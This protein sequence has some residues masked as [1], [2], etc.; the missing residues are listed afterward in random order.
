MLDYREQTRLRPR[1][2]QL[3]GLAGEHEDGGEE[4]REEGVEVVL[5]ADGEFGDQCGG[6]AGQAGALGFHGL[7]DAWEQLHPTNPG[8]TWGVEGD[9]PFPP[10][11]LDKVALYNLAPS[12]I[13]VLSPG[14]F[15]V[16]DNQSA[17]STGES[18]NSSDQEIRFSDHH[19]LSCTFAWTDKVN[20]EAKQ[21]KEA[22]RKRGI[23]EEEKKD[24]PTRRCSW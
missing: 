6:C 5:E 14:S 21:G 18:P 7:V 24:V 17:F 10:N 20:E 11:R 1:H 2:E 4:Y 13:R 16:K 23:Q 15:C 12:S 9:K 3:V 22:S 8:Y 19:G